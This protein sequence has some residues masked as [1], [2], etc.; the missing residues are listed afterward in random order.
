MRALLSWD[1]CA[2]TGRKLSSSFQRRGEVCQRSTAP[3]AVPGPARP[4]EV[5]PRPVSPAS[6]CRT[7]QQ[8][9][10]ASPKGRRKGHAENILEAIASAHFPSVREEP[11]DSGSRRR[12]AR[13]V[14]ATRRREGGDLAGGG[15]CV[16]RLCGRRGW[17]RDGP[18]GRRGQWPLQSPAPGEVRLWL[19]RRTLRSQQTRSGG[20]ARTRGTSQRGAA[21]VEAP[22]RPP[23][24]AFLRRRLVGEQTASG[25]AERGQGRAGSGAPRDP[26]A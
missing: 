10:W 16:W 3:F 24:R 12:S 1:S 9:T 11:A 18:R 26:G 20:A 5:G 17:L 2:V 22:G 13:T 21:C 25:C 8:I 4:Q 15:A 7:N 19:G 14:A 23:P 6:V